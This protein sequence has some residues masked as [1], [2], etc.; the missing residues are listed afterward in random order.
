MY[1]AETSINTMFFGCIKVTISHINESCISQR[2]L[3]PVVIGWRSSH[4]NRSLDRNY[5][6]FK[7]SNHDI[8]SKSQNTCICTQDLL[9]LHHKADDKQLK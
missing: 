9:S 7:N 8:T 4:S 1:G 3:N 5:T 6:F 2:S